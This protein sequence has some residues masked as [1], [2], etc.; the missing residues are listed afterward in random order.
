MDPLTKKCLVFLAIVAV[1]WA[2]NFA[3][4]WEYLP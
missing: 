4:Q 2:V 1:F 3:Y